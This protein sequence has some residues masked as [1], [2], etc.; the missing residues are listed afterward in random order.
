MDEHAQDL[1][2]RL[3]DEIV[4]DHPPPTDKV[5]TN[6]AIEI[7]VGGIVRYKHGRVVSPRRRGRC[8]GWGTHGPVGSRY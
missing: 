4:D 3:I 7:R 5:P 8:D 1:C 6:I 2:E